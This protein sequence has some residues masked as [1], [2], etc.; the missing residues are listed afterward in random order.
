MNS[1]KPTEKELK[2]LLDA[3][4]EIHDN[5]PAVSYPDAHEELTERISSM[6]NPP[7]Y[8]SQDI[9]IALTKNGIGPSNARG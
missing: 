6:E 5:D 8:S 7:N 2:M 1:S 9:T 3:A 4:K